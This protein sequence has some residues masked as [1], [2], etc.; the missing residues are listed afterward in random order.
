MNYLLI[1]LLALAG[2][3]VT[4]I[5]I[6]EHRHRAEVAEIARR[7]RFQAAL[8]DAQLQDRITRARAKEIAESKAQKPTQ[9]SSSDNPTYM[10][11]F[12]GIYASASF[13]K[14]SDV[15]PDTTSKFSGGGGK[16]DGGGASGDYTP[17]ADSSSSS[18]DSSSSSSSDGGGGSSGGSD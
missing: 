7:R 9:S 17:A 10:D 1:G 15:A 14:N 18:S 11:P 6:R 16:F 8:K 3:G 4:A 13:D 2:L 5:I 12:A